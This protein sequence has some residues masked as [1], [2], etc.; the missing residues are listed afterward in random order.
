MM[1][2]PQLCWAPLDIGDAIGDLPRRWALIMQATYPEG[3]TSGDVV[4]FFAVVDNE[5]EAVYGFIAGVMDPTAETF[6][7]VATVAGGIGTHEG[8]TGF[9][10][11]LGDLVDAG[12]FVEGRL[13]FVLNKTAITKFRKDPI[14]RTHGNHALLILD[15]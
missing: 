9:G 14:N 13:N 8:Y 5:Q 3:E 11:F 1:I 2:D 7:F 12:Q 15:N 10:T 6:S 4:G